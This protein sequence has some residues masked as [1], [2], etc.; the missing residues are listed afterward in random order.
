MLPWVPSDLERLLEEQ[1]LAGG[2]EGYDECSVLSDVRAADSDTMALVRPRP[3]LLAFYGKS[4]SFTLES[5]VQSLPESTGAI[6][7][8]HRSASC[9]NMSSCFVEQPPVNATL[10]LKVRHRC[11]S[12][13]LLYV[14]HIFMTSHSEKHSFGLGLDTDFG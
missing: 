1:A 5:D 12:V 2:D 4:S 14:V 8:M 9:V 7:T 11:A 6:S 10:R 13:R 3:P